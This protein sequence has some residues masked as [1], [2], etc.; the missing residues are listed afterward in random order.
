MQDYEYLDKIA[1]E[2]YKDKGYC[3]VI[4]LSVVTGISFKRVKRKL[5][6][7]G[8]VHRQGTQ[9]STM[10]KFLKCYDV[11]YQWLRFTNRPTVGELV[12][13]GSKGTFLLF[14]SEHVSA[15][16]DS[17]LN[18]HTNPNR[19]ERRKQYSKARVL[20]V[21]KINKKEK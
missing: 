8:R 19:N 12:R 7:L 11:D 10:L 21:L 5:E 17:D 15:M 20:Q 16:V 14:Q 9:T 1:K 18:D 2:K 13:Q 6:K 3:A 4:A